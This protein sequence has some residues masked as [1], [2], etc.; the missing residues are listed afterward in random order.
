MWH[1]EFL[2][3]NRT[4]YWD[5]RMFTVCCRWCKLYFIIANE[6]YVSGR[7]KRSQLINSSARKRQYRLKWYRFS[8]SLEHTAASSQQNKSNTNTKKNRRK[9]I[10]KIDQNTNQSISLTYSK[11]NDVATKHVER[12]TGDLL[13]NPWR[14]QQW[15]AEKSKSLFGP[16]VS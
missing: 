13:G 6:F 4:I 12:I 5:L 7:R 16:F 15:C 10:I 9:I 2:S 3:Q 11:K 1:S 8:W 14:T